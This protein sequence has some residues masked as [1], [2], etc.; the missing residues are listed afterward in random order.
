MTET[1]PLAIRYG[2]VEDATEVSRFLRHGFESAFGA[3]N[4]PVRLAAFLAE[5]FTVARQ[6]AEL[7]DPAM[8]TL[9]AERD[10]Q[11]AGVAQVRQNR[12]IPPGVTGPDPI[13]LQRFYVDPA[14]IGGGIAR[15]LMERAR[16]EALARGG[17]TFWLGVW[18]VNARAIAFYRKCGFVEV[19]SHTFDVGGDIQRD[20]VMAAP[21]ASS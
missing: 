18:E 16:A 8:A 9:I 6:R 4:D 19:G 2:Q 10:G 7:Q 21:L 17:R 12:Y 5:T 20:L 14:L 1:A 3:L 13:E 11:M 15:P